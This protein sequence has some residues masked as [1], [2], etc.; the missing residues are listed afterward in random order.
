MSTVTSV[1]E[2][3]K[4]VIK[5]WGDGRLTSRMRLR[6]KMSEKKCALYGLLVVV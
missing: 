4:T 6:K 3:K 1:R 5:R 2:T